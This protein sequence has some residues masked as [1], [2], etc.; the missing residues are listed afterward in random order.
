MLNGLHDHIVYRVYNEL[1]SVAVSV[2]QQLYQALN[3]GTVLTSLNGRT[4]LLTSQNPGDQTKDPV[5]APA[6]QTGEDLV[7]AV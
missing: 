1:H 3:T 6:H 5:E 2:N 7:S 4:S